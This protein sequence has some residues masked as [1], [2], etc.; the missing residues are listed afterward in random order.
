M[1][2]ASERTEANDYV[3]LR[4]AVEKRV[5]LDSLKALPAELLDALVP[6]ARRDFEQRDAFAEKLRE[7]IGLGDQDS[8]EARQRVASARAALQHVYENGA[9]HTA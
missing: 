4:A 3:A 9:D 8:P 6:T 1:T 2:A 5:P 7:R